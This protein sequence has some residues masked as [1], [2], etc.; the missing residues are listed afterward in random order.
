[1][2]YVHGSANYIAQNNLFFLLNY[3]F[4]LSLFFPSAMCWR[5]QSSFYQQDS[6]AQAAT[7]KSIMPKSS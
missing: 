1:M 6:Q 7:P 2:L 4:S 5:C 3:I